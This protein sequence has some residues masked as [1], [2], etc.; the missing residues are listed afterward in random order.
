MIKQGNK[1][2]EIGEEIKIFKI[3]KKIFPNSSLYFDAIPP[4]E[5]QKSVFDQLVTLLQRS[6]DKH[7]GITAFPQIVNIMHPGNI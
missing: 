2:I 5:A 4:G 3:K 6:M 7:T 1:L